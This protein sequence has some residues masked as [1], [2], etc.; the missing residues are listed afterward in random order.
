MADYQ[1]TQP[2]ATV[3]QAINIALDIQGDLAAETT[4]R[5]AADALLATKT[6]LAGEVSRAQAAEAL[7]ATIVSLNSEINRATGAEGALQ[8][9][10]DAIIAKIPTAASSSNQLADKTWVNAQISESSATYRGDY[11]LVSDL[12]LTTSATHGQV[13]T[14]LATKMAALSITPDNNDYAYVQIPAATT[15]PTVIAQID[16]YKYN[17]T[18]WSFEYTLNNSGFTAAQWAAIN[19]GITALLVTKLGNLPTATALAESLAEKYVKPQSGIPSTDLAEGVQTS[20]GKADS[21]YQKPSTGIPKTDL[22]STSQTALD[23][24]AR[25]AR[26]FG[27]YDNPVSVTLVQAISG[28][29]IDKDTALE[30]SNASYGISSPISLAMGDILLVPSA[31]AVLAA[32]SVVSRKVTS[33]YNKAIIYTYTYDDLNRIATVKADYDATLVYTAHYASDEA[34][35][36]DYWTI[37]SEQIEA[38]PSTHE[39]TESFYEPLV[40]QSVAAMPSEGYYVFLAP[41][42][43]EVVISA[44]TATVNGGTAIKVGWGIFKN[45]ASNFVG[46][47]KQRVI[48]EAIDSLFEQVRGI[49]NRLAEGLPRLR[50]DNLE[51]GNGIWGLLA[52]G[53]FVLKCKGAPSASLVPDNWDAKRYG[54][55]QGIALFPGQHLHDMTNNVIYEAIDTTAVTDWKRISNA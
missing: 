29:Y 27:R 46:I 32:C 23:N 7:L 53:T 48:A 20:L 16:R 39:V 33:T 2:G 49:N 30:V 5:E 24:A 4:A 21:A 3:Q 55:W 44:F 37:G 50:V 22:E 36:P 11:N 31:S 35:Q 54:G 47:D 42:T 38:L 34:T 25:M 1:L 19:S 10:I 45:I 52:D 13:E 9:L 15:T 8:S 14:A 6:E 12:S 43:M 17:G 40:K 51:I 28:K 18:A 41:T 26:D